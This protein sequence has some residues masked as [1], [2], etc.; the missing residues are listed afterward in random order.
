LGPPTAQREREREIE[1]EP[2]WFGRQQEI[3][4][5]REGRKEAE[6]IE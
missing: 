6:E 1:R 2:S 5:G 4:A 3:A